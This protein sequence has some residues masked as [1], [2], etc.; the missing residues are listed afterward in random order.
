MR[1]ASTDGVQS[2]RAALTAERGVQAKS[3]VCADPRWRGGERLRGK[4]ALYSIFMARAMAGRGLF[5][6]K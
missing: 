4:K 3:G 1:W 2:P 5:V 6:M